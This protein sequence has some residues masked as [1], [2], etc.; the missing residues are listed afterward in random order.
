MIGAIQG[1]R[2]FNLPNLTIG[3]F[4]VQD[5]LIFV[6]WSVADTSNLVSLPSGTQIFT[7][8]LLLTGP[9]NAC[10][11]IIATDSEA[12]LQFTKTFMG[13]LVPAPFSLN[14][15]EICIAATVSIAGNISGEEAVNI[16]GVTVTTTGEFT[17]TTADE[18]N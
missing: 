5:N 7:I 17:S 12:S 2:D 4:T 3:N 8:D 11:Q 9:S 14:S 6:Y 1:F 15:A 10:T 13:A 18:G 16:A